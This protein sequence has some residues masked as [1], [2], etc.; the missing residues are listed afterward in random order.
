[1]YK[2]KA[3]IALM[4]KSSDITIEAYKAALASG[5]KIVCT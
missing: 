4:Q 3:E 1:M 2:S 5:W